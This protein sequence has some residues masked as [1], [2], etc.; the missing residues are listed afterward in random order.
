LTSERSARL[1]SALADVERKLTQS[2]ES[3]DLLFEKA[4][5]LSLLGQDAAAQTAYVA[6][7]QRD[8]A[9]F[10]A[11]TNLASLALSSGHRSAALTA[12]RQA[13]EQH[14][15][16]PTAL[17]NYAGALLD[18]GKATEARAFYEAALKVE[19]AHAEAHQ[20]LARTLE[21]LGDS[22][23]AASHWRA[24]FA[25]HNIVERPY[26]G[27][28]TAPRVLLLVSVRSGNIP[29][30]LILDDRMF[31][32]TALYAE[33][34]DA[35]KPLP[36]HDVLFNAIGDA[37]LC[38]EGLAKACEIVSR[39]RA[40]VIN[41]PERVVP[42][43]RC[44]NAKRLGQL[45]GV[46]APKVETVARSNLISADAPS[47]LAQEE[48]EFPLLLRAPGFH[49]GQHFA[50]VEHADDLASA[51]GQMPGE[52][53]LAIQY[54]DAAGTDGF[55]RK[56]RVM[57]IDGRFYP[58]HMAASR[59]WKV[60][61]VTSDMAS[62]PDLRA[63]EKKF[64]NAMPEVLGRRAMAALTRIR[65]ALGLDYGGVD[66]AVARDGSLLLFEANATMTILPPGPDPKWDYRRASI[67]RVLDAA[68]QLVRDRAVS[69]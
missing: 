44:E 34:F 49:T 24:G 22:E 69:R 11:L 1:E 45:D 17:V 30:H 63:E 13:A 7:L 9:H 57:F 59:D 64:L 14:P 6:V 12:Y 28:G 51:A 20:G 41:L 26:R 15:N 52:T 16:N 4:Q 56:Y 33:F 40:P 39:S 31:A 54:L 18:D 66:F 25:G 62:R 5:L 68:R 53:V 48:F 61:Y 67:A 27:R 35:A 58:V 46:I 47:C 3:L 42:T 19:L 37:D 2:P 23:A 36:E 10:G 32:V 65:E 60:H 38:G 21:T 8:Q 29:T 55:A 43:G 50:R